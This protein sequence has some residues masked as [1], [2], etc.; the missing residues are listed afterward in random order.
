MRIDEIADKQN[1]IYLRITKVPGHSGY[2][3]YRVRGMKPASGRYYT[4]WDVTIRSRG[5][6]EGNV[7][8]PAEGSK[9]LMLVL[10]NGMPVDAQTA[11]EIVNNA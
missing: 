6:T 4:G 10:A 8:Y 3:K 2:G 7:F 9:R 1:R 11:F 5:R